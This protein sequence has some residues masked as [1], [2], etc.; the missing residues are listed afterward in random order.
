MAHRVTGSLSAYGFVSSVLTAVNT[1][2]MVLGYMVL[3]GLL[4][5]VAWIL[6]VWLDKWKYERR[7]KRRHDAEW[8]DIRSVWL[9]YMDVERTDTAEQRVIDS[10]DRIDTAVLGITPEDIYDYEKELRRDAS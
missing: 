3:A 7:K 4:S 5:F 9:R 2:A 10:T 6:G 1:T 8:D